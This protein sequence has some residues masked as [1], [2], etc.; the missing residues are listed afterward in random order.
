MSWIFALLLT[1]YGIVRL[2]SWIR[3]QILWRIHRAEIDRPVV[4]RATPDHLGP[5]SAE[6]FAA[7]DALRL[8]LLEDLRLVS[9]VLVTD[10]DVP[11][12]HL[13]DARFRWAVLDAWLRM[14]RWQRAVAAREPATAEDLFLRDELGVGGHRLSGARERIRRV[15]WQAVRARA[16]DPYLVTDVHTVKSALETMAL[17]LDSIEDDLGRTGAD[18]YRGAHLAPAQA[19][20]QPTG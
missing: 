5:R 13:R 7:T 18:P 9:T 15:W 20:V 17:V 6:V 14:G 3:G 8:A 19:A 11:L 16:L 4:P 2:V 10:P 12:G 1:I